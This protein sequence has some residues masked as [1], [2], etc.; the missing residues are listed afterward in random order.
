MRLTSHGRIA[1]VALGAT[2]AVTMAG[3]VAAC[4]ERAGGLV[5]TAPT[6]CTD[7]TT[8]TVTMTPAT[9]TL[10]VGDSLRVNAST[11]CAGVGTFTFSSTNPGVATVNAATGTVRAVA[12]GGTTILATNTV[13]PLVQGST[14]VT[15][16]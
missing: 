15:V 6:G 16:R 12:V 14:T 8:A 13:N 5:A 7:T 10:T 4:D 11:G 3:A 2:L 1:R 9:A